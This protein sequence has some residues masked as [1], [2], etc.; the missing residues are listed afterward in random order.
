MPI[1]QLLYNILHNLSTVFKNLF[2]SLRYE[3]LFLCSINI[4]IKKFLIEFLIQ[5]SQKDFY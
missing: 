2:L 1:T 4:V 5:A 3:N